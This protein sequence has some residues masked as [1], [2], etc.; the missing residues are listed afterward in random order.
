MALVQ[1]VMMLVGIQLK[2]MAEM[3]KMTSTPT[4]RM[5]KCHVQ[6][7]N[8]HHPLLWHGR[9]PHSTQLVP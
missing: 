5:T 6:K 1:G 8:A 2:T 4:L 7:I 3:M 9:N